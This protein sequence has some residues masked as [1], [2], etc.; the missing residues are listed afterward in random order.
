MHSRGLFFQHKSLQF[1]TA[2]R[3]RIRAI[4]SFSD[5]ELD[6]LIAEAK[7]PEPDTNDDFL[8]ELLDA[9]EVSPVVA[10]SN[11]VSTKPG[12]KSTS[13]AIAK[14]ESAKAAPAKAAPAKPA[15]AKA[16]PAKPAPA[17][18]TAAPVSDTEELTGAAASEAAGGKF[19]LSS[20]KEAAK[21]KAMWAGALVK[22]VMPDLYGAIPNEDGEDDEDDMAVDEDADDSAP[23]GTGG[24]AA[25][26]NK[27]RVALIE[28]DRPHTPALL[29]IMDEII[30]NATDHAK[31]HEKGPAAKRVTMISIYYEP[32]TGRVTVYNDGPGLPIVQHPEA[33][34]LLGRDVYVPEVAFSMFL[35]GTNIEKKLENIKGGINGLG[36]KLANVHSVEFTVETVDGD[37]RRYYEQRFEN[38]L[39]TIHPPTLIELR[40]KHG[41][42]PAQTK[43]HTQIS[44]VPAYDKLGYTVTPRVSGHASLTAFD[45]K[46]ID[47]WLRLRAHQVAAYLGEKVV[48]SYNDQRCETTSAAMLG[49]LLLTPLTELEQT[50]ALVLSGVAKSTV[51][52]YKQH[53][54]N[55]AV[56]VLPAGKKAGRRS[57]AQNMTVING[58]L[59]N[60]GSHVQYFK[61]IFSAAVEDKIRRATKGRGAKVK[62]GAAAAAVLAAKKAGT[63]VAAPAPVPA[64]KKMSITETLA[65]VRLVICGAIPGADWSGQRKDELQIDKATLDNYNFTLK[66]LKEIGDSVAERILTAQGAKQGKVVHDKYT[67]ARYAGKAAHKKNTYLCAAEGD[68]AISLLRA[69]LTQSKAATAPGGPSLDWFGIISLQGVIVNAAREVTEVETSTGD[70]INVRSAKLQTNKRLLALADAFGLRYD[71]TYTTAEELA[72]LNYQQLVLCVDQDLDGIGKIAPLVL[73]WIYL[74]WPALIVA[75]RVGRFMTPLIRAYPKKGPREPV[76]FFYEIEFQRWLDEDATRADTHTIKYY[77][78]LATHDKAETSRMFMPERFRRSLYTYKMDE[79]AER[80]FKVYFSPVAALRKTELVTPVQHLSYEEAVAL[81]RSRLI[82]MGRV[83]LSVDTK[84]YKNDAIKRQIPGAADGLNPARRKIIMGATIRFGGEKVAKELKVFQLG[85]F[86]ADKLFYHH[87]D[88][89]L[90]STIIYLAQSHPGSR[91]YPYLIGVG[92][93]GS[94]HGD[95]AGSARYIA[96]KL[97]PLIKAVFPP[98]D[99]WH[100]QYVFEDGERA[101]PRYFV[102][103]VPMAALETYHIVSEGWNHNGFGRDL[104]SV[105]DIV[106]AYIRGEPELLAVSDELHAKGPTEPVLEELVRLSRSYALP[107]SKRGFDGEMR[108]YRDESYSFGRYHWDEAAR[109]VTITELPTGV[110]TEKYLKTLLA[111]GRGGKAN[112]RDEYIE[113]IEDRSSELRVEL[114]ITLKVGAFEKIS[115][116]FGSASIDPIEDVLM[117]RTSLRPHLNYYSVDGGVLEFGDCYL[118]TIMYWAHLRRQLYI[119]RATR[120]EIVA[121]LCIVEETETIRYIALANELDLAREQNDDSLIAVLTENKFPRLNSGLLHRPEYTPNADL[122]R[123]V[124]DGPGASYNYIL[125]LKEREL[126]QSAVAKR[127]KKIEA[128]RDDLERVRG[129]LAEQPI[130]CAS[131]WRKEIAD[132]TAVVARGIETNWSFKKGGEE[133]ITDI[134]ADDSAA[135]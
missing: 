64:E 122:R 12:M 96:V 16:A 36:A 129:Q 91:Q 45:S 54:L 114:E 78:G 68:S 2:M 106:H 3:W 98:S 41:L 15:P 84:L 66:Y 8:D 51:E 111:P 70:T 128:L 94:R 82:P 7:M 76:E 52:P 21:K 1:E 33:S 56:V 24:A 44:F 34:K 135:E 77:K 26:A 100:L 108:I 65:G 90:N 35:A 59:S 19:M 115:E 79:T 103:V 120:E 39:D 63:K 10:K 14:S 83:Q 75:G 53:P 92:Q 88:A 25:P 9:V 40:T 118:A 13:S 29:K 72:T 49:R 89:S 73:V 127:Q 95:K 132:F 121:E 133:E 93:F 71:R 30:V 74:F 6:A 22:V 119:D 58:V 116:K 97:S 81:H 18:K 124:T 117:L 130:A 17:K 31:E 126:V 125:D 112:P 105:L 48:V 107:P 85:G 123:L 37:T 104:D 67:R 69:G 102:P 80:L 131:V 42:L 38:R 23:A 57:A 61:S 101:E 109:L 62:A 20:I 87:G 46:D 27:L 113:L 28:I 55:F 32:S 5:D 99:R 4:M 60:K 50:Q 86:V 47:S 43:P 11:A 134:A 110:S